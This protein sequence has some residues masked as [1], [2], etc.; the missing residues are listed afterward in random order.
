[1]MIKAVVTIA[2]MKMKKK[3]RKRRTRRRLRRPRRKS[4]QRKVKK[5]IRKKANLVASSWH[6]LGRKI[7]RLKKSLNLLRQ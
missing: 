3:R 1:M 6:L 5:K 4:L 7:P 2:L